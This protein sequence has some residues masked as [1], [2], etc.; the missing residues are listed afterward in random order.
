MIYFSLKRLQTHISYRLNIEILEKHSSTEILASRDLPVLWMESHMVGTWYIAIDI[1]E[2]G[3]S[4]SNYSDS[5]SQLYLQNYRE[6]D[7]NCI[8]KASHWRWFSGRASREWRCWVIVSQLR[9]KVLSKIFEIL[10][11]DLVFWYRFFLWKKKDDSV[12]ICMICWRYG[13]LNS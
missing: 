11:R 6:T 4:G 8:L 13:S 7:C 1:E 5:F 12:S 10:F 9:L 3:S 2:A